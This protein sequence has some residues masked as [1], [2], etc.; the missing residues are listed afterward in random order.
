M[1]LLESLLFNSLKVKLNSQTGDDIESVKVDIRA[2][3]TF[4]CV[5]VCVYILERGK[6]QQTCRVTVFGTKEYE[7]MSS[8]ILPHVFADGNSVC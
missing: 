3:K 1:I 7:K 6:L 2:H 5:C 4:V 8:V